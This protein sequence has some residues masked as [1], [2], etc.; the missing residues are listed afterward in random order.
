MFIGRKVSGAFSKETVCQVYGSGAQQQLEILLD[1][2]TRPHWP[3]AFWAGRERQECFGAT[4]LRGRCPPLRGCEQ[5]T[6]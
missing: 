2:A 4:D 1:E 3:L 6:F 5:L